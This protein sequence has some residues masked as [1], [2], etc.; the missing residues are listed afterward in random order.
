MLTKF[1]LYTIPVLIGLVIVSVLIGGCSTQTTSP[2]TPTPSSPTQTTTPPG[3]VYELTYA[4]FQPAAAALS[5]KNTEFAQEL[6]K[7]SNGRIKIT[8]HGGGS[9]LGAPAMYQGVA[10]G[11]ADMGNGISSYDPG[12]FPFTSI[13][14]LPTS[15][16]SGWAISNAN[17]DLLDKYKP[18]EWNDVHLLTTVGTAADFLAMMMGKQQIKTIED[19]KGKSIR[20]NHA[21]VVTAMGGTVKDVPMADVYDSLSKGVL[22]G[23]MGSTEPLKSWKLGEVTKFITLNGA[24]VQPSIMWYNIMN[25]DTWDS[26]PADLQQIVT[27]VSREYSGKLGL[28]WDNQAVAGIQFAAEQGDTIYS[29][30]A[31]E[32][33]RWTAA[34]LPLIDARLAD[35]ATKSGLT[36]QQV[37]E[38]WTYLKARVDYWNSQQAANNITPVMDRMKAAVE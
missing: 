22:D 7:R 32:E 23:V 33:E 36:E 19:W 29:L 24:P 14:E 21:D 16:E 37:T 34:I 26:L 35:L 17:Y 28:E 13:A 8:V 12:A 25:K 31:N 18:K 2:G 1:R 4:L 5:V 10:D 15:A 6:E 20:T 3:K 38:A 9:L 27:D 30:P 11:I